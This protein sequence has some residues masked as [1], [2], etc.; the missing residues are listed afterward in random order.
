MLPEI[1][2]DKED[3]QYVPHIDFSK[4]TTIKKIHGIEVHITGGDENDIKNMNIEELNTGE[5]FDF[6]GTMIKLPDKINENAKIY[7]DVTTQTLV[8]ENIDDFEINYS[9]TQ[10]E[11]SMLNGKGTAKGTR[12][13]AN[14]YLVNS[15][16]RHAN[17]METTGNKNSSRGFSFLTSQAESSRCTLWVD[18]NSSIGELYTNQDTVYIHSKAKVGKFAGRDTKQLGRQNIEDQNTLRKIDT[19]ADTWIWDDESTVPS[20]YKMKDN[21]EDMAKS[22]KNN[23]GKNLRLKG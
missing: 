17:L 10:T 15:N 19:S 3:E 16:C 23:K 22:R 14:I 5:Y 8:F 11:E 1:L 18:R 9:D 20:L 4:P 21:S 12:K 2:R 7:F 6:N 13:A